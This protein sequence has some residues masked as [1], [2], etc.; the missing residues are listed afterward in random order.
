MN[1]DST[2]N[3][4]SSSQREIP[5]KHL[6]AVRDWLMKHWRPDENGAALPE[7]AGKTHGENF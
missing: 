2:N 5:Q 1:R 6:S 3:G 4:L 7:P